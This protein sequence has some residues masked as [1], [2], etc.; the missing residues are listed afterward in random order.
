MVTSG[1]FRTQVISMPSGPDTGTP[2]GDGFAMAYGS[3]PPLA[4]TS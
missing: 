1:F 3:Q 4:P 2:P